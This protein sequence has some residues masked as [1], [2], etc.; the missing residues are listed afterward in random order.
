MQLSSLQKGLVG[1]WPLDEQSFNPATKR[2]TDRSAYSNHGTGN[3][4]QLG[5]ATPGFQADR[6]GQL[7]RAAPFN[8]TDDDVSLPINS[9]S[10]Q[11]GNSGSISSWVKANAF[12]ANSIIY[13]STGGGDA[14]KSPYLRCEADGRLRAYLGDGAVVQSITSDIYL[15]TDTWYFMVLKWD[16]SNIWLYANNDMYTTAQTL[17]N[18][19]TGD[20]E[21]GR[22]GSYTPERIWNGNI[23]DVRIYN[24]ALSQQEITLLYESY[25]PKVIA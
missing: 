12:V 20:F 14:D 6:M 4:T 3:G 21:I 23:E 16:G 10:L 5:S 1:H 15:S 8:G 24:R 7:V 13:T 25:R 19:F 18:Q 2:F 11:L 9:A 17:T 22:Y